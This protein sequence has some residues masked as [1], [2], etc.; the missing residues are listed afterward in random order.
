MGNKESAY[1]AGKAAGQWLA[2]ATEL[3]SRRQAPDF[4]QRGNMLRGYIV[5]VSACLLMLT[6]PLK[7]YDNICDVVLTS[8]AFNTYNSNYQEHISDTVADLICTLHITS[9]QDLNNQRGNLQSGGT[10]G[11]ISGFF[12][13]AY[14]SDSSSAE[15]TYD[16]LCNKHDRSFIKSVF[17]SQQSQ[18]TN[19]NVNAWEKCVEGRQG[20]F[21][22]LHASADNKTYTVTIQYLKPV[23][24]VKLALKG[25]DARYGFS[26]S[27]IGKNISEF[28][29]EENGLLAKFGVT[30]VRASDGT[31]NTIAINTNVDLVGPF[32]VP[33]KA[34]KD[35]S[36][37][38]DALEAAMPAA[39]NR[40]MSKVQQ[41]LPFAYTASGCA[42]GRELGVLFALHDSNITPPPAP[43]PFKLSGTNAAGLTNHEWAEL[44]VCAW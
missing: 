41:F 8:K 39:E 6:T 36:A 11:A 38:V 29:P 31:N 16:K 43:M 5:I 13:A 9:R 33:S 26:C 25:I 7:A 32:D 40:I 2:N 27:V 1:D 35:L 12:D 15:Q 34:F 30:C 44:H 21:S 20:L 17:S 22:A 3:I 10:Y 42:I 23:G 24:A 4:I 18:M 37:R 14:A 28:V 19:N